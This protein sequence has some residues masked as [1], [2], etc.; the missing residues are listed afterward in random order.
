MRKL[1]ERQ[2]MSA[3]SRQWNRI[4]HEEIVKMKTMNGQRKAKLTDPSL[5]IPARHDGGV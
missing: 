5:P 4:T 3:V 1:P 2:T